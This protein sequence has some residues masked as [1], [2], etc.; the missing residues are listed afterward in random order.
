V[1]LLGFPF[2][3]DATRVREHQLWLWTCTGNIATSFLGTKFNGGWLQLAHFWTLA[4]AVQFY[5]F[6][7]ILVLYLPARRLL[8]ACWTMVIAAVLLKLVFVRMG[9]FDAAYQFTPCPLDA[10]GLGAAVAGPSG[11]LGKVIGSGFLR[12]F[13]R[14]THGL[15]V[16]YYML[17]PHFVT[18]LHPEQMESWAGS[19]IL[20]LWIFTILSAGIAVVSRHVVERPFLELK[21]RF[22][23]RG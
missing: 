11:P 17:R 1:P 7:P 18:W 12:F 16:F 10:F 2:S 15:Y 23:P 22:R 4:A 9:M 8:W 21:R 19:R 6:W 13:G 14:Y 3:E 20:G 5:L